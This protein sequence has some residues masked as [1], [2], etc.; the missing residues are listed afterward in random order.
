MCVD[1]ASGGFSRDVSGVDVTVL[2][3]GSAADEAWAAIEWPFDSVDGVDGDEARLR[4]VDLLGVK[5]CEVRPA[6]VAAAAAN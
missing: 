2:L 3:D 1:L 5:K 6:A 4:V